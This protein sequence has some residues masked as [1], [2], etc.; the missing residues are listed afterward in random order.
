M[1]TSNPA[2]RGRAS[3]SGL[4]RLSLVAVPVKAYPA[5]ASSE[6]IGLNQLHRQCKERIRYEKHC[7]THGK[8]EADEIVKG[9]QFAPDRYVVI[10]P[11]ELDNIRPAKDKALTLEQ[12]VEP[13]EVDAVRFSG[14]TLHLLPDGIGAHRPYRVL[15]AALQ[16]RGLWALG[17]VVMSGHRY[18][19]VVRSAD[20][21][22]SAHF[23]HEP[24]LVRLPANYAPQLRPES[25]RPEELQLATSLIDGARGPVDFHVYRDDA[26]VQLERLVEA[27]VAG[28]DVDPADMEEPPQVT[29]LLAALQQSVAAQSNQGN[30]RRKSSSRK[31]SSRKRS[32]RRRSA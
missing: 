10:E 23:L 31:S 8:L 9:Y 22:L 25:V 14:R 11:E 5:V 12:F 29:E 1:V 6:A 3:W 18:G 4:L 16:Q 19:V 27:K 32:P 17:R 30:S 7:P 24:A 2:P 26:A 20:E 13:A 15:A 21:V 28:Q